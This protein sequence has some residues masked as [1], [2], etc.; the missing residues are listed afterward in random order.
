MANAENLDELIDKYK[1]ELFKTYEKRSPDLLDTAISSTEEFQNEAAT[2]NV[3]LP[4]IAEKAEE[5]AE[6]IKEIE[7]SIYEETQ[8][9]SEG[10]QKEGLTSTAFFSAKISTAG[11]AYPVPDAKVVVG[12]D[13]TIYAFLITDENGETKQVSLPAYPKA[14][15]LDPTTVKAVDYYADVY[16]NGF[17]QKKNLLVS[18]V[19]SAEIL[20]NVELTPEQE[21][22]E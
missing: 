22:M 21:R 4:E 13:N 18:A 3:T 16:A 17:E 1:S 20:L 15:S 11:G 14:D 12:R 19:G 10:A 9:A 5:Q 7:E 8:K 2:V 6:E